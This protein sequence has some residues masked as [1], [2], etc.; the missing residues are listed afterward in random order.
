MIPLIPNIAASVLSGVQD[1]ANEG[2]DDSSIQSLPSLTGHASFSD[3]LKQAI[4][5]VNNQ[6]ASANG[7]AM[8]YASGDHAVSLSDAMVSLE[9][10]NVAFQTAATVRD[11][12]T[13]A[14]NTVM[15]MQL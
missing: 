14:Y 12:I 4:D 1:F 8:A 9:K 3:T 5:K 13:D 10:A 15:N 6:V 2:A 7:A 11:R